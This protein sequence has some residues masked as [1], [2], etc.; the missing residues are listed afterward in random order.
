MKGYKF[1]LEAVLKIRKLKEEQCKMEIGR[2]QVQITRLKNEIGSHQSG[3]E[4]AY[5]SQ[6]KLMEDGVNGQEARFYP[7]FVSGK[8][9][10]ISVLQ[11]EI[12]DLQNDVN[13]KFDELKT[14][15]AN[16]KVIDEMKEK[17][18]VK[19]KKKLE[20]KQFEDIEEQVQNWNQFRKEI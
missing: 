9:A 16:V 6:E 7:Y 5:A 12:D 18:K 19:Y 10:H 4:E 2:M 13:Q 15:R 20:K 8:R 11:S 3:I 14:L 17:D 1:K